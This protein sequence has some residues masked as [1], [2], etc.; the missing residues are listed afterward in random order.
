M[1]EN[2]KEE[3]IKDYEMDPEKHYHS[4]QL[5][6]VW[7]SKPV[8]L[9]EVAIENPFHTENFMWVDSGGFRIEKDQELYRKNF[10]KLR[11]FAKDK[12]IFSII[13]KFTEGDLKKVK[14][15]IGNFTSVEGD[16]K[17]RIVGGFYGGNRYACSRWRKAYETML[18]RYFL[19]GLFAGKDQPV[20]ASV[21]LEDPSLGEI[22]EPTLPDV[23]W[24]AIEHWLFIPKYL[25]DPTL[26]RKVYTIY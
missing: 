18:L 2:Y 5:Y 10:P 21:L 13:N 17:D 24:G 1:W 3:W 26:K 8:W 9:E 14:T 6:A 12:L 20:M 19:K 7:A 22:L 23:S 25:S 11:R 15:I 4:P 16:F